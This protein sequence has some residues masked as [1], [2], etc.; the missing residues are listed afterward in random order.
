MRNLL[1]LSLLLSANSAFRPSYCVD[2]PKQHQTTRQLHAAMELRPETIRTIGGE[3]RC[4]ILA[5]NSVL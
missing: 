4:D 3:M 5:S 2:D 1:A